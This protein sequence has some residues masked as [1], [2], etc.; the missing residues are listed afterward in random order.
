MPFGR[1]VV[2]GRIKHGGAVAF[3]RDRRL[4]QT[5][6]GLLQAYDALAFARTIDD[7]AEFDLGALLERLARNVQFCDRCDEDAGFAIGDDVGEL[8][9]RQVGIDAGVI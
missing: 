3:V 9:S 4:G 5:G 2:P 1:P 8:A 6:R 7:D